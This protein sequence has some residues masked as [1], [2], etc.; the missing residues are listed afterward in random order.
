MIHFLQRGTFE[1]AVLLR[2]KERLKTIH[3]H[4][5]PLLKKLADAIRL[6]GEAAIALQDINVSLPYKCSFLVSGCLFS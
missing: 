2:V 4:R 1:R 3:F 5:M 6:H